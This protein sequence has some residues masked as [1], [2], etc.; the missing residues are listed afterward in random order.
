MEAANA[1]ADAG[2]H[3]ALAASTYRLFFITLAVMSTQ[4]SSLSAIM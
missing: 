3:E 4:H 2:D 1:I